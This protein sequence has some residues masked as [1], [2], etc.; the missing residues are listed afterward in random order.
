MLNLKTAIAVNVIGLIA[1]VVVL[2]PV[3]SPSSAR[4]QVKTTDVVAQPAPEAAVEAV[5]A[6]PAVDPE[7]FEAAARARLAQTVVFK[8]RAGEQSFTWKQVGARLLRADDL[9]AHRAALEEGWVQRVGD[10]P[11]D[12]APAG[13]TTF[14]LDEARARDLLEA[15]A[16]RID[17]LPLAA[18]WDGQAKRPTPH[19]TGYR[20]DRD[21]SFARLVEGLVSGAS[22]VELVTDTLPARVNV[23]RDLA[24]FQ[25]SVL[26]ARFETPYNPRKRDR[27]TNLT[28]AATAIDGFILRPGDVFSYNDVVGERSEELGWKMAPVIVRG[29]VMEGIGGGACQISSTLHAASLFGGFDIVERLNHTLPSKYIEPGLDASVTWPSVDLK[30][31]NPYSFPVVIRI[32]LVPESAVVRAE[33]WGQGEPHRVLVRREIDDVAFK[34]DVTVD[35]ELV[36][37]EVRVRRRGHKGMDVDRGRIVWKNGEEHFERLRHD[38]YIPQEKRVSIGPNT[39]YPPVPLEDLL[40]E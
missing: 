32:Y 29:E 38:V 3:L 12:G 23:E 7:A 17:V 35:P 34:E 2:I 26:M 1:A 31:G 39:I 24:D 15:L 13:N 10:L 14:L 22:E 30:I 9:E 6:P 20:L 16:P 19:R 33:V 27:V 40:D 25:P 36:P 4:E 8:S 37:G 11:I 18:R 28:L 21:A 5:P